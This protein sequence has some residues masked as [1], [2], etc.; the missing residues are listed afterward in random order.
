[1]D[2]SYSACSHTGKVRNNNEDNLYVDGITLLPDTRELP[3]SI[4]GNIYAPAIFAVCDGMGGEDNGEIASQIAVDTLLKTQGNI[5]SNDYN[6][7]YDEVRV[8]VKDANEKINCKANEYGKRMGTTLALAIVAERGIYCF[9]IGDSRIYCLRKS[10]FQQITND[11]T[12]LA[13]QELY[14]TA[15]PSESVNNKAKHTLTR[16]IGIGNVYTAESYDPIF[17]A[18]RMLICSDGLSDMVSEK[19][20][21]HILQTESRT[22]EAAG[23]LLSL[24]LKN[25]GKDNITIIVLDAKS[26]KRTIFPWM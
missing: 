23:A 7:F 2:I 10:D 1:M 13:M 21:K 9:N 19:E 12:H 3:F 26:S 11:H 15:G 8:C 14:S 18:C 25:G 5:K 6:D 4:D 24:A 16:C 20:I 17:G 22:S